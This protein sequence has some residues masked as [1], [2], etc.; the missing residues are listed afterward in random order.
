MKGVF[1]KISGAFNLTGTLGLPLR[2]PCLEPSSLNPLFLAVPL[3]FS[4][5]PASPMGFPVFPLTKG[6]SQQALF[7]ITDLG[8]HLFL[9]PFKATTTQGSSPSTSVYG[10]AGC[11]LQQVPNPQG[12]TESKDWN[13]LEIYLAP[14]GDHTEEASF[15]YLHKDTMRVSRGPILTNKTSSVPLAPLLQNKT[16]TLQSYC[17]QGFFTVI[18]KIPN[19]GKSSRL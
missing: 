1:F 5:L 10:C 11:S 17:F 13:R 19:P 16:K 4:A 6:S 12:G 15:S 14:G 9:S 3:P 2:S 18:T 7:L 8:F